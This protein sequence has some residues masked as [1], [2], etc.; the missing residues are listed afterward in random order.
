[1]SLPFSQVIKRIR[2][3]LFFVPA[4]F[5]A[6]IFS[7]VRAGIPSDTPQ[8]VL[9]L[10]RVPRPVEAALRDTHAKYEPPVGCY[11]GAFIDF[12]ASLHNPVRDDNGTEH[13]EPTEFEEITGKPHASYFFYMGYGR[14]LPMRWVRRL[15]AQNKFVHIAL[16]PN[17]GLDKVKND[18]YLQRLADDMKNSGAKIFLRFASEMNG[19]WSVYS[20]SPRDFRRAF[21]LVYNVMHRRAPNVALVW[22]PYAVSDSK[23]GCYYPRRFAEYYPGD[24]ATDWVGVNMYSVTYHNNTRTAYS[25]RR[26]SLR[27]DSARVQPLCRQKTFYDLRVCRHAPRRSGRPPPPR[28]RTTQ[29]THAVLVSGP[30]IPP[31]EMYQ[32]FRQQQSQISRRP[33]LQQLQRDR[34]RSGNR[35]VSLFDC[36]ARFSHRALYRRNA[37]AG[38]PDADTERRRFARISS[39]VVLGADALPTNCVCSTR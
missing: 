23:Y 21:R 22:C 34:R 17:N 4:L 25:R 28:L 6:G 38:S 5:L 31:R 26:A 24:D 20:R 1:M 7:T 8:A 32:L 13:F 33:R 14:N 10:N 39:L 12:D 11:L 29:D 16:E 18:A 30:P 15:A 9:Y 36:R 3:V 2:R 19:S 27:H 35:G 37:A